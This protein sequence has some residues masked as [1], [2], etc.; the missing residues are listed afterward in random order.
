MQPAM[1]R[2]RP[3]ARRFVLFAHARSGS[4]S[5]L[6]VLKTHPALRVAEEPFHEKSQQW[7]PEEPKYVDLITDRVSSAGPAPAHRDALRVL[8]HAR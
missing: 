1:A 7:N 4:S 2:G 6:E 5:L 3:S 8:A